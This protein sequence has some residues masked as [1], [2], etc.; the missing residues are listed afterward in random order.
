MPTTATRRILITG[1]T[2]YIGR[3]L[4]DR[5]L[6]RADLQLRLLVR[7]PNRLR[8][9]VRQRVEVVQG[10][11]F[12]ATAL[13]KALQQVDVAFYL[14]HSMGSGPDYAARDRR[15]A[16][17]FR[18]ACI[19]AGVARLIYLGGLGRMENASEHLRSRLET[20][21]ILSA[22][23]ETLQT[24]WFR[25]GVILGAGS[26][27]FE[28]IHHLTQKL[29]VML[30][31]R[32][33]TTRTQAIAVE[34]VLTYLEAAI[35]LPAAGNWQID[36]GSEPTDFRGLM[37]AAAASLG[38]KRWLI[39]VPLLSPKLSS[40]WL[41][42]FTPVPYS[43]AAALVEGLK[44][45]TLVENDHAKQLFPTIVPRTLPQAFQLALQELES[46]AVLS[47][48][49]DSSAGEVCDLSPPAD[50]KALVYRDCRQFALAGLTP[51]RVFSQLCQLGGA[52]GWGGYDPLWSLRGVIDKLMGGVGLNRGRR[53][54]AQLRVGDAVDFWKVV[55]LR[56]NKRLLLLAQMKL[57]GKGWLEFVIDDDWLIQTAHFFP[58][59]LGGRLYWY[60]V[61]PFHALVFERM[62][63]RLLAQAA[64]MPAS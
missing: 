41:M 35:D 26:A 46:D 13:Q 4:K 56:S 15:S 32:W 51:A 12:D 48:W 37:Q 62:G 2:G 31:P 64:K 58:K 29:P 14:I 34:D 24:L 57:P 59:G 18:D 53:V 39:P 10:D 8:P 27:S 50:P 43:I 60:L 49:C 16:E 3:R 52:A 23:P 61:M 5:L 42:L 28:I 63:R 38:L 1:A 30:T 21:A 22:R 7:D 33:V 55:D 11:S 47:R 45:E 44:S 36:I 9:E 17:Q 25:A 19:A 40:Y 54:P 20:G 6:Q